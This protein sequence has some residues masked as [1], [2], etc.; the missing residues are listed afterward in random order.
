[1]YGDSNTWGQMAYDGRYPEDSQW[2][3][4]LTKRGSKRRIIQEGLN[5]RVAGSFEVEKPFRNGRLPFEAIF[6]S[7]LPLDAVI[8]ALGTNDLKFR[9][10]RTTEDIFEDLIWYKESIDTIQGTMRR[11]SPQLIYLAPANFMSR[12]DYFDG[13]DELRLDVIALL[14]KRVP[15]TVVVD[16]LKMSEDG[17]HYSREAHQ[18]VAEKIDEK[19]KELGL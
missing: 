15:N 14:Q 19:L 17:V 5:A 9:Y 3:N 16:N 11:D 12:K 7:A 18:I 8:I 4:I 10:K 1:M 13:N 2:C 6:R